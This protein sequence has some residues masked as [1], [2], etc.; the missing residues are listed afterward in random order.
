MLPRHI[1]INEAVSARKNFC[2]RHRA[3]LTAGALRDLVLVGIEP[4]DMFL[5]RQ[6]LLHRR[7]DVIALPRALTPVERSEHARRRE[8]A[9]EV[10]GLR[11][12]RP[13]RRQRRIAGDKQK[14]AL[15]QRVEIVARLILCRP[16]LTETGDR[17]HHDARIN[18]GEILVAKPL[19]IQFAR[20]KTLQHD[21]GGFD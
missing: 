9:R 1:K 18:C 8:Q 2:R 11:F 7:I 21:V 16:G 19:G 5:R 20:L 10:I 4:N 17:R 3:M 12:R 6:C 13:N 15:R 14:P